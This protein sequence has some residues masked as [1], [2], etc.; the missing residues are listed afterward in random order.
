[1]NV[2]SLKALILPMAVA[3]ALGAAPE[4]SLAQE[5]KK[6]DPHKKVGFILF[7][8]EVTIVGDGKAESVHIV[9]DKL[10]NVPNIV[11]ALSTFKL[12]TPLG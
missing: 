9:G 10:S 6:K 8:N 3:V 12:T 2:R 11:N 1:M 4:A 7:N 5:I